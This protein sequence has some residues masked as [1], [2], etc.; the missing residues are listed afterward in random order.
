MRVRKDAPQ[1]ARRGEEGRAMS[2]LHVVLGAGQVGAKVA[3][4]LVARGYR[5][6][7]VRRS[8]G[9]SSRYAFDRHDEG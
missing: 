3:E 9:A 4:E 2:E 1:A 7:I 5:V 8:A 6:R